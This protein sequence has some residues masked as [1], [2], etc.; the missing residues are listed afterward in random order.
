M[1]RFDSH[2]VQPDLRVNA[3]GDAAYKGVVLKT[4]GGVVTCKTIRD[5]TIS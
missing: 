3:T 4:S 5:G 2:A 1:T